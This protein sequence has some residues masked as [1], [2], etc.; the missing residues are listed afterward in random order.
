M[1]HGAAKRSYGWPEGASF[2][3]PEEA[4]A[5]FAA[6]VGTR[7][8]RARQ[9]WGR[10]AAGY[11]HAHPELAAELDLMVAGMLPAGWDNGL[12]EFFPDSGE[13][14]GRAASQQWSACPPG[15]CSKSRTS[16]TVTWYCHR[17]SSRGW[18]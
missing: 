5:R 10:V 18:P 6:G 17:T 16:P 8:H 15:R 9:Q 11:Q 12:Q 2:L 3:V 1:K 14:A 7:G 4:Y 13:V